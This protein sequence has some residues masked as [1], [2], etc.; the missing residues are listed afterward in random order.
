M[1]TDYKV[2]DKVKILDGEIISEGHSHYHWASEMNAHVG[3]THKI[4]RIYPER[5]AVEL[6]IPGMTGYGWRFE[7][8]NDNRD[9]FDV[10]VFAKYL[11]SDV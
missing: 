10:D 2:G 3:A 5:G 11:K 6:D 4:A 1:K 7:W 8:I 9:P